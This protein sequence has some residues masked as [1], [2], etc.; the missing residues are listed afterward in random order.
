MLLGAM[1]RFGAGEGLPSDPIDRKFGTPSLV[2]QSDPVGAEKR[3]ATI[4]TFRKKNARQSRKSVSSSTASPL[5]NQEVRTA[6]TE[7]AH[8]QIG[9]LSLDPERGDTF[10]TPKKQLG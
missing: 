4:L 3:V 9:S 10:G 1:I 6:S 5:D 8:G 2:S 7:R